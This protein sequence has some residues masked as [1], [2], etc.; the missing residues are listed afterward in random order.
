MINNNNILGSLKWNAQ[1]GLCLL[2][3]CCERLSGRLLLYDLRTK[4]KGNGTHGMCDIV[5]VF[6]LLSIMECL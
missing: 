4:E 6:V 3:A 1:I 2:L 5:K